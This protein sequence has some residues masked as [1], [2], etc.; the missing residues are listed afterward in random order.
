MQQIK[1]EK[2]DLQGTV[3]KSTSKLETMTLK[4]ECS[5]QKWPQRM[6]ISFVKSDKKVN[7]ILVCWIGE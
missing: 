5:M 7:F 3:L 6:S 1:K 2:A 4:Q